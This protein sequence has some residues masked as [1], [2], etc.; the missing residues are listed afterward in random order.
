MIAPIRHI[1]QD[2]VTFY[3]TPTYREISYAHLT[4]VY[5]MQNEICLPLLTSET[6]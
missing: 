3:G 5:V 2:D 4:T 1:A 6:D